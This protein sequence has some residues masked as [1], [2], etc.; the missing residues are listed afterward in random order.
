VLDEL[1]RRVRLCHKKY[2]CC[3]G[4]VSVRPSTVAA[5]STPMSAKVQ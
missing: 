4:I 3:T 5:E 2:K 1:Q